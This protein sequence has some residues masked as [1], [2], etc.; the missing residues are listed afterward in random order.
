MYCRAITQK[1]KRCSRK[2]LPK[3]KYCEM[4]LGI[5]LSKQIPPAAEIPPVIQDALYNIKESSFSLKKQIELYDKKRK[6]G[7]FISFVIGVASSVVAALIIELYL[8]IKN[9]K[10]W[11]KLVVLLAIFFSSYLFSKQI[12]DALRLFAALPIAKFLAAFLFIPIL[13]CL[14]N[15]GLISFQQLLTGENIDS[16]E[17]LRKAIAWTIV[18]C[19]LIGFCLATCLVVGGNCVKSVFTITVQLVIATLFVLFIR[20]YIKYLTDY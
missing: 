6:D 13:F 19:F 7:Y 17:R 9:I 8:K 20:A 14:L 4:H 11:I 3:Q 5:F 16:Y 18:E 12:F 15:L 1:G 10:R 2:A